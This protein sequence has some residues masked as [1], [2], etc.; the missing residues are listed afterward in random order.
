MHDPNQDKK[1]DG[2]EGTREEEGGKKNAGKPSGLDQGAMEING[3]AGGTHTSP[4]PSAADVQK[5]R[6]TQNGWNDHVQGAGGVG[7]GYGAGLGQGNGDA[8]GGL[9]V[10]G[11]AEGD[12][13]PG[14]QRH[15]SVSQ[16]MSPHLQLM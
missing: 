14:V 10:P 4:G 12:G 6:E 7:G 5:F 8:S 13:R 9:Q 16:S 11:Q 1:H 3:E 2:T 15:Y